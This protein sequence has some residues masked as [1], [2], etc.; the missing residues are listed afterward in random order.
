[1][2]RELVDVHGG[3][4][5]GRESRDQITKIGWI[6]EKSRGKKKKKTS[7]RNQRANLARSRLS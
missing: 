6:T 3:L 5:K 1:M 7:N 2:K 4:R